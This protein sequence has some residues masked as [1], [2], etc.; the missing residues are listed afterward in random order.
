MCQQFDLSDLDSAIEKLNLLTRQSHVET[1]TAVS[2]LHELL[3]AQTGRGTLP[4][5]AFIKV[6]CTHDLCDHCTYVS[7]DRFFIQNFIQTGSNIINMTI[8]KSLSEVHS[9]CY[10]YKE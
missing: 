7:K 3:E 5:T 6:N 9:L 8:S 1:S 2:T 4:S 10:M